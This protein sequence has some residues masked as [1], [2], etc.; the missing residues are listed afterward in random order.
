MIKV[1]VI[2]TRGISS[3]YSGIETVLGQA[4]RRLSSGGEYAFTV[5][6]MVPGEAGGKDIRQR[7]IPAVNSKHF[8]MLLHSFLSTLHVLFSDND[9]V[10]FHSLGPSV[11]SALPRLFG[12]K[13]VVTV[14]GLDWKRKKW[15]AAARFILR[16]CEYS[17]VFFPNR[18]V[19]VSKGLK[20]YFE[21]KFKKAVTYIPNAVDLQPPGMQR[22]YGA[23]NGRYILFVGRL[24][25]EKGLQHLIRAFNELKPDL[26]LVI[27]G[28]SSF[29]GKYV[30]Q[31]KNMAG[32]GV[33]FTGFVTGEQLQRLYREA[34]LFVLPSEVEGLPVSLLEAMSYGKCVLASDIPENREAAGECGVYFKAGDVLD[35]QAKLRYLI[36]YPG[37]TA[38]AGG[39]CRERIAGAYD[40]ETV[41]TMLRG[42]YGS[43]SQTS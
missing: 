42:L 18:T 11:F 28:E 8:G 38:E 37:F 33:V 20:R 34:Y 21:R 29:T 12:K 15:G 3:R 23:G 2:G 39:K 30:A 25:P 40:W 16:V 10:H 9:I 22:G 36:D 31:L 32:D 24:V 6:S 17:A 35:L 1:A 13:T 4:C 43:L 41:A 19:V 7:F 26:K 27:A 14:H 5:Y